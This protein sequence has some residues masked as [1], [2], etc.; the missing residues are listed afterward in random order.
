M[1]RLPSFRR[2]IQPGERFPIMLIQYAY[3]KPRSQFGKQC[4]FEETGSYHAEEYPA[5]SKIHAR[6]HP[7]KPLLL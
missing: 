1:P 7:S 5:G 2:F 6:L 3:I 4:F